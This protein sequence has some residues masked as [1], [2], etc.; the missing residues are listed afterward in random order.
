MISVAGS[1]SVGKSELVKILSDVL[2][3]EALMETVPDAEFLKEYYDEPKAKAFQFQ[4]LMMTK[5][6]R[7]IKYGLTKTGVILDQPLTFDYGVFARTNFETGSMSK[8]DW[9]IYEALFH[10]MME[11]L[12]EREG[13]NGRK[14]GDL[15]IVLTTTVE[16]MDKN[17]R[18]RGREA[19]FFEVGD[20]KYNY[21]VKLN[22]NANLYAETYADMYKY[23]ALVID[24]SKLDFVN[25][26][27]DRSHVV[28]AILEA[29]FTLELLT[30]EESK[31]AQEK[32]VQDTTP[33]IS[34]QLTEDGT[35]EITV[36]DDDLLSD[37]AKYN[38][39]TVS[40][41]DQQQLNLF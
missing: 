29:M 35:V 4:I 24:V 41:H 33:D 6:F 25:S 10:E 13:G 14:I 39:I 38:G 5:R 7:D 28:G 12:E 37:K 19:E 2:G 34:T 8:S 32:M 26:K 27:A 31:V 3:Y 1:P 23:P 30:E 18:K 15:N 21:F 11:E 9:E 22:E 36:V 17:I 20:D 40:T 16:R